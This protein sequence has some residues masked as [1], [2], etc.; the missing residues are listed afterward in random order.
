MKAFINFLIFTALTDLKKVCTLILQSLSFKDIRLLQRNNKSRKL[1]F[2]SDKS[3]PMKF[4]NVIN[5]IF[6][7]KFLMKNS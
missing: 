3:H 5:V 4:M 1:H 7:R 2:Y 6:I